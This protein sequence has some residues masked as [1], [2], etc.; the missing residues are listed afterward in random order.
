[1]K[2][3]PAWLP[4]LGKCVISAWGGT[5]RVHERIP[6]EFNPRRTDRQARCI[7]VLWHRW[8][9][10]AVRIYAGLGACA[11]ISQHGDGEV[12]ARLA[13]RF[14]FKT[15]RGSST[16]GGSNLLRAMV[17]FAATDAGDIA[18]TTDGPRGPP[19]RTKPGALFLAAHLGWPAVPIAFA[20]RPRKELRSWDRFVVPWPFA[21]I[22][23][24]TAPPLFVERD[25]SSDRIDE[26]CREVDRRLLEAEAQALE[27]IA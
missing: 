21:K 15:A 27:L 20:A 5:W 9:L 11:G 22:A 26:L 6:S 10:M 14:G 18:L 2:R 4:P 19:Q 8:I 16:R 23:I 24:V 12:A 1:V 13:E 25:A 3:V 17:E 7:Y